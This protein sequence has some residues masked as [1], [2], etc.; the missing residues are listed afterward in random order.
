MQR[1]LARV[2]ATREAALF[3]TLFSLRYYSGSLRFRLAAPNDILKQKRQPWEKK[4]FPLK[5]SLKVLLLSRSLQQ[6]LTET[7]LLFEKHAF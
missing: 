7:E 4:K 5:F 2:H 1:D 6:N 3:V